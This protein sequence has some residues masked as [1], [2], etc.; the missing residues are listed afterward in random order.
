MSAIMGNGSLGWGYTSVGG[1]LLV[2]VAGC[3]L[4]RPRA[5][6]ASFTAAAP[7]LYGRV[8]AGRTVSGSTGPA[9]KTGSPIVVFARARHMTPTQPTGTREVRRQ[10][11]ALIPSF[12]VL[13]VGQEL[14]FGNDDGLCHSFFSKSGSNAFETGLLR[15][16]EA[17][18]VRFDR[19]GAVQI[20]CSLHAERQATILVVPTPHFAIVDAKGEFEIAGLLPGEH[21]LVT[22]NGTEVLH[23]TRVELT[24]GERRFVKIDLPDAEAQG[25]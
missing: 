18:V 19:P 9:M 8:V 1:L 13:S 14:R 11:E 17:K 23:R 5:H 6:E 10:V 25:H 7:S 22:W 12:L 3:S 20:Y 21:I 24:A 16:G 2:L 15:P 4:P